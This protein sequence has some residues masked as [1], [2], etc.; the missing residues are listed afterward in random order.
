MCKVYTWVVAKV[1]I[2]V[3][4]NLIIDT[5]TD[6]LPYIGEHFVTLLNLLVLIVSQNYDFKYTTEAVI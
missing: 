6:E 3:L 4:K 5:V 1:T 2:A